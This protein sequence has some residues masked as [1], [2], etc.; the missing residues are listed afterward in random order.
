MFKQTAKSDILRLK[1]ET[2]NNEI[3]QSLV[4]FNESSSWAKDI[5]DGPLF[6]ESLSQIA[7]YTDATP[8]PMGIN[9]I[10]YLNRGE[11]NTIYV[12]LSRALE[13]NKTYN[14]ILTEV[15][16]FAPGYKL[17][18]VDMYTNKTVALNDDMSYAISTDEN[19][20]SK[21]SSR[22]QIKVE[23]INGKTPTA[24]ALVLSSSLST[25]GDVVLYPQPANEVLNLT[26][27]SGNSQVKH[28]LVQDITGRLFAIS[29]EL[30]NTR[31]IAVDV[32]ALPTGIYFITLQGETEKVTHKFV[33]Q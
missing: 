11:F 18:L 7:T 14:L 31:D 24:S 29:Y 30:T 33:K 12:D 15:A 19:P 6:N 4:A 1:L 32:N 27:Q 3:D 5:Y 16:T 8:V 10:N 20:D 22:I 2:E 28:I 17:S 26:I 9:K 25:K 21:S 23:N 13:S